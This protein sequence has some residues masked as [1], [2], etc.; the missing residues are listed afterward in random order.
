MNSPWIFSRSVVTSSKPNNELIMSPLAHRGLFNSSKGQHRPVCS[1]NQ[2]AV[3]HRH[4][5]A[6]IISD[7]R[8]QKRKPKPTR[9]R[10]ICRQ[11]QIRQSFL[12]L[13]T[14]LIISKRQGVVSVPALLSSLAPW[15][16]TN[17]SNSSNNSRLPP[18]LIPNSRISFHPRKNNVS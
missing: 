13:R 3:L 12:K 4:S 6:E 1:S 18:A 16:S 2:Y 17:H 10:L 11:G 14:P 5:W 9:T 15:T 7:R 8:S